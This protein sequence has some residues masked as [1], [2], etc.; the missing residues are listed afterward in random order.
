VAGAA[1]NAA[2]SIVERPGR[3]LEEKVAACMVM[4]GTGRN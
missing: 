3:A 2:G 4:A 1:Q